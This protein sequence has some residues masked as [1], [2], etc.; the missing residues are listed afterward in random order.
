[1]KTLIIGDL[2]LNGNDPL[3]LESQHDFFNEIAEIECDRIV[4]LGDIFHFRTPTKA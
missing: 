1:M 4:F 3:Y 2:H